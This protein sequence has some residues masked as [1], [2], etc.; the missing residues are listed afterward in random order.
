[1]VA[2]GQGRAGSGKGAVTERPAKR[3]FE[4][5]RAGCL[6]S[7]TSILGI[8]LRTALLCIASCTSPDNGAVDRKLEA[9]AAASLPAIPLQTGRSAIAICAISSGNRADHVITQARP[10]L[11]N[12]GGQPTKQM[13]ALVPEGR[14]QIVYVRQGEYV[15][16]YIRTERLCCKRRVDPDCLPGN[17][18]AFMVDSQE[19]NRKYYHFGHVNNPSK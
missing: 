11:I 4:G 7:G 12:V 19:S 9:A 16:T 13:T 14:L 5:G 3:L 1:M 17:L 15:S 8:L 2:C 18:A 10:D 6:L